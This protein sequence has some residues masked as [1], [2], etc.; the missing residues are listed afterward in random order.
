MWGAKPWIHSK[1]DVVLAVLSLLS[2][3]SPLIGQH[4][5][6]QPKGMGLTQT[7]LPELTGSDITVTHIK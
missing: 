5:A 7:P 2:E 1:E 6:V 4:S 3:T